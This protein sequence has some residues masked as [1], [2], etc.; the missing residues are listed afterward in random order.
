MK[1]LLSFLRFVR[2]LKKEAPDVAKQFIAD[3]ERE[4]QRF[5]AMSDAIMDSIERT[6]L[7]VFSS[8]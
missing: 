8:K 6:T 7:E 2:L 3:L 4:N 1:A 5:E